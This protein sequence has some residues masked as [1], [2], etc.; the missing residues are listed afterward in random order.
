MNMIAWH[1]CRDPLSAWIEAVKVQ[2]E[3][4]WLEHEQELDLARERELDPPTELMEPELVPAEIVCQ[5][6][7]YGGAG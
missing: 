7:A 5:W 2:A 4:E 6:D 3:L 1:L